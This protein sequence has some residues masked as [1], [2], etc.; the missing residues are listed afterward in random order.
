MDSTTTNREVYYTGPFSDIKGDSFYGLYVQTDTLRQSFRLYRDFSWEGLWSLRWI[1]ANGVEQTQT[2]D[3]NDLPLGDMSRV[4]DTAVLGSVDNDPYSEENGWSKDYVQ[5]GAAAVSWIDAGPSPRPSNWVSV[6]V[7]LVEKIAPKI[8][9]AAKRRSTR[10]SRRP[11]V[12][13]Q[14]AYGSIWALLFGGG[15][16]WALLHLLVR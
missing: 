15:A 9:V 1:D 8:K 11:S 5:T 7:G 6:D 3:E 10:S 2:V 14:H 13:M 12:R 16:L 4:T